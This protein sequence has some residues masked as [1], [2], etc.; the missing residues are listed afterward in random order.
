MKS[1]RTRREPRLT[2][3]LFFALAAVGLYGAVHWLVSRMVYQKSASVPPPAESYG[4]ALRDVWLRPRDGVRIH[5]WSLAAPEAR[6]ATLFLH[7]NA[8]N[9][10]HRAPHLREIAAAGSDVLIIDYRGYGGNEGSPSESGLLEDAEAA[11]D[12]LAAARKPIVLH[13]E[14]LGSAVAV[15]LATRRP[16]AG[17]VLEAPFTSLRAMAGEVL[18]VL[19]PLL[20]WGFDSKTRIAGLHVPLLVIHGDQDFTVPLQLGRQLY[21]AAPGPKS[22]WA[23]TGAGHNDLIEAAGSAYRDHLRRFY[24]HLP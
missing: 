12:C 19:G 10:G 23:V 24:A 15:E 7:G 3:L 20:L 16:A 11:Y 13:G 8:G 6:V 21:D 2:T 22:F 1:P 4:L 9:I 18:P 14:S 17:L 5:G